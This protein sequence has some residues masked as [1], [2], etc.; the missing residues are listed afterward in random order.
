MRP[1]ELRDEATRLLADLIRI[2]TSNPHERFRQDDVV[3][4]VEA[5]IAITRALD[6]RA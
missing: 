4:Q 1:A 6:R 5:A 2:D 3:F